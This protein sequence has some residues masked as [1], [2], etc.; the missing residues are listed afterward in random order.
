M[1]DANSP[2]KSSNGCG[3]AFVFMIGLGIGGLLAGMTASFGDELPGVALGFI[4]GA[5][6]FWLIAALMTLVSRLQQRRRA[7]ARNT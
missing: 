1:A 3:I 2:P 6:P 7:G 4:I 5:G